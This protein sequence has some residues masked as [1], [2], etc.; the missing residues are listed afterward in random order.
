[1][2]TVESQLEDMLDNGCPLYELI[3]RL[4]EVC[5]ERASDTNN[6]NW[7]QVSVA[8]KAVSETAESLA[9]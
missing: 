4:S 8:L 2:K 5:E 3:G 7:Q 6:A 1:M 9:L